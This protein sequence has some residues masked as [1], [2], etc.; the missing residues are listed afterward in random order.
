MGF[1][2]ISTVAIGSTTA[3]DLVTGPVAIVNLFGAEAKLAV[4]MA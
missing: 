1:T 4:V 3:Y 2:F